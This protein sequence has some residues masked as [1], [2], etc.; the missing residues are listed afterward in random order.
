[1]LLFFECF[2]EIYFFMQNSNLDFN[3]RCELITRA[4]FQC[5]RFGDPLGRLADASYWAFDPDE[6]FSR[7]HQCMAWVLVARLKSKH[8]TS[9]NEKED[10]RDRANIIEKNILIANT[11]K[12]LES[13]LIQ[14]EEIVNELNLL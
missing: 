1:M 5:G 14:I 4:L 11:N 8:L 13:L 2:F 3:Y 9:L 12:E 10:L 7:E 6:T